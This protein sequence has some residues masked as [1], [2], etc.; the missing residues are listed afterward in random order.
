MAWGAQIGDQH[1]TD[2]V[3]AVILAG[4][5]TMALAR[6]GSRRRAGSVLPLNVKSIK[7]S[8]VAKDGTSITFEMKDGKIWRN[9]LAGTCPDAWFNGFAWT[10]HA[11]TVCDNE[12]GLRVINSGQICKLG[13]F[14][15]MTPAPRG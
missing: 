13:K 4:V 2:S 12:P 7:S 8:D 11:D 10:V 14:T 5:A 6:S 1:E 3:E 15:Q 9:E